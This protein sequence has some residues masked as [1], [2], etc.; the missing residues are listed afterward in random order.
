[1]R[2][3]QA[4][5]AIVL[6]AIILSVVVGMAA[7]AI[8]GARAY[9]LRRDLEAAV[10][11]AALAAGDN[12]QQTGSYASAEQAATISFSMN[13]RLY[14][15][16]AC[17]P[18]YGAPTAAPLTISCTYSDG[19]VLTQVISALGAAGSLFT[20]S[21]R[22]SLS[23]QFAGILTNGST[24][25]LSATASGGVNNLLYAPTLAALNQA[26]CGGVGGSAITI[27]G[28]ATLDVRGDVVSA[29]AISL[30]AGSMRV[31][32]DIYSRCQSS[33]AGSVTNSCYPDDTSA[34]CT[35]PS[36]VGQTRSGYHS[37]DPGYPPPA[38]LGGS[39]PMPSNEVVLS[40]GS[41][42][43]NPLV[44]TRKCYF[45]SAGAY[46]WLA[47]YTNNGGFVS[48]ELKPPDEPS[49]TDNTQPAPHQFWNTNNVNCAGS[50]QL[51][52]SGVGGANLGTW[53]V[54]LTSVRTDTHA[55]VSYQ[56][57]SA[58]SECRVLSNILA[59]Q[60]V[61]LK[62]SNVPGAGSYN[63]YLSSHA[64]SGPFGL[65][66]NLPVSGP[67]Q[68]TDTSGCPFGNGFNCTLGTTTLTAPAIVIPQ[69][70][71]PNPNAP[72]GTS[73]AYPPDSETAPFLSGLPN[74]NPGRAAPPAGD[75]A[76][77]NQCSTIGAALTACP[78]AI[79]P[80]AVAFYV[81]ASGCIDDTNT[82]DNFVFGGYQ[83]NWIVAYEPGNAS[84]P[85]NNCTNVL[86]AAGNSS[87]IGLVYLPTANV[88]V[89]TGAG[90]REETTGGLIANM[91]TFTG[92][93]PTFIGDT[94][95]YGPVPPAAKLT[96]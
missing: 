34:P 14:S 44:A 87:Y 63:V 56:R 32:G 3:S 70:P 1:M 18:A 11:A 84:P 58:P 51:T 53:G 19:T 50:Y 85:I 40:P 46:K 96:G 60:F 67:V 41:Y 75:R 65:V 52:L 30:G 89:T 15:G 7:L 2:S 43:A 64:C 59:N 17:A 12:L 13:Q 47:G 69:V 37:A 39:N 45:L 83:Y 71:S 31:A 95:D 81:P 8:D 6:I 88:S 90:V 66:Y 94:A 74:R 9:A 93:L 79:T 82:G 62:I 49:A 5:Q 78:A 4:G 28:S 61:Q 86:G 21:A 38:V 22:R 57:E 20:M 72:P 29:G 91:I 76:N 24:P 54:L 27:N 68:N 80:G 42:A 73:G 33:V 55:G 25:R 77:E 35:F 48:N 10:D 26:G 92:Q 16:P 23:L 36:V